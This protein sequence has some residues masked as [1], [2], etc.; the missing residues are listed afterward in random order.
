MP[1]FHI[2]VACRDLKNDDGSSAKVSIIRADSDEE[3][4]IG[5]TSELLGEAPVF[6]EM[7][8]VECNNLDGDIL[9][10]TLLDENDQTRG[11]GTFNIAEVQQHEKKLGVLNMS[12]GRGTIVVHVAEKVQEGALRLILKGKD[13]KNTEGFTNLRKPDPFYVLSRKGDGDDEWTKV[14]DSGVVKNSLD[15][16]WT[17]CEI[18]VKELC[19]ADFDLP[20]KLQVFDE[21]RGDT[22]VIIGSCFITVNE[23]LAMGPNDGK[24][25]AEKDEKTGELF[26]DGCELAGACVNS[27]NEIKTFFAAVGD[28]LKARS[29]ANSKLEQ[30]ETLKEEAAAAKEAAEKAQA[31]AEQKAQELE[32]AEGELESVVAAAEAAEEVIGGLE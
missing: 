26:V 5:K 9:K 32:A 23:L 8:E 21:E 22:H 16:E 27:T 20:L 11:V 7:L 12:A 3:E 4:D 31:E 2:L 10:V 17:E 18:D 28:A 1:K 24:D 14:F 19:S 25:I 29:A 13:L 6:D 30:I 15:P